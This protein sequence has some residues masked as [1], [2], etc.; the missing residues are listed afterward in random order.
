MNWHASN[1]L[2]E[3]GSFSQLN[4]C[5]VNSNFLSKFHKITL[6]QHSI[7]T[8]SIG[9]NPY[10]YGQWT[11]PHDA[12]PIRI[13]KRQASGKLFRKLVQ[14]IEFFASEGRIIGVKT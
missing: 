4:F 1:S 9:L 6:Y 8:Y 11:T 14:L 10:D 7:T 5:Q 2:N 3:L 13:R 12:I